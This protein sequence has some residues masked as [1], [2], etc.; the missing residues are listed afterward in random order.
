MQWQWRLLGAGTTHDDLVR[1]TNKALLQLTHELKALRAFQHGAG[2]AGIATVAR[3]DPVSGAGLGINSA[4]L[5]YVL[6]DVG[7][8]FTSGGGSTAAAA[9]VVHAALTGA[10]GDTS[11]LAQLRVGGSITTQTAAETVTTVAGLYVDEPTI[12]LGSGSSVTNAATVYIVAAPTEGTNNY[13]LWVDAGAVRLDGGLLTDGHILPLNNGLNLGSTATPFADLHLAAAGIINFAN[14]TATISQTGGTVAVTGH[15]TCQGRHSSPFVTFDADDATPSVAGG[16]NFATANANPT[17]I[18]DFDDGVDGQEILVK[19]TD[20]NTTIDFTGSGLEGNAGVNW[21][22]ATGDFM[23]CTY[24]GTQWSCSV[25]D[26][27]A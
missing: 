19:I 27:T 10:S 16:K 2:D 26:T 12:T 8:L 24:N 14:G 11:F 13:A 17:T 3:I 7:G 22:P 23:R 25:H 4:A 9:A 21:T 18:T 1:E 6:L 5:N 20:A 15:F